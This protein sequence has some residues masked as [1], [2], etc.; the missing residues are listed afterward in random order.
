MGKVWKLIDALRLLLKQLPINCAVCTDQKLKYFLR[1]I[2]AYQK[3]NY[4]RR[5]GAT[6]KPSN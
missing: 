2:K 1:K 6:Q 3:K 4:V 5:H